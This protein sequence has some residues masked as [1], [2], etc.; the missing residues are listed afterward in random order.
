MHILKLRLGLSLSSLLSSFGVATRDYL[1]SEE[2]APP[3]FAFFVLFP[4]FLVLIYPLLSSCSSI[5][6]I[7]RSFFFLL[8]YSLLRPSKQSLQLLGLQ[9]RFLLFR[10]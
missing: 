4:L 6:L 5:Y 8:C 9:S 1:H 2:N 3:R 7:S 10:G